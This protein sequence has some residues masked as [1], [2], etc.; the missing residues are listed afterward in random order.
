MTNI[1]TIGLDLAKRKFHFVTL[2]HTNKKIG[3]VKCDREHL[4]AKLLE[5]DPRSTLIAMEA[6]SGSHFWARQISQEGFQVRVI[7]TSDV[8]AYAKTR[9]KNDA[10][11]ALAIAKTA[12][13]LD[14]KWVQPK[15]LDIQELCLVHKLRQ[16]TLKNR[17]QKTNALMGHLH[18]FGYV[19]SSASK[20]SFARSAKIHVL[21][22]FDQDLFCAPTRDL[23]VNEAE[24]IT[25]LLVKERQLDQ[26]IQKR[27][28]TCAVTSRLKTIPGIGDIVGS[29]M[30]TLS[31]ES[32]DNAR[33][34]SASLGLV[35]SQYTTGG[36]IRLGG[37][38]K[39]GCRYTRTMLIQGARCILMGHAKRK[40]KPDLLM[41][42]AGQIHKKKGF[43]VAC[44]AIANKLAR[45]CYG[46]LK[47]NQDYRETMTARQANMSQVA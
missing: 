39:K 7:K 23:L 6:C 40:Q 11:D 46:C 27:N 22:A 24:E 21:A 43:N 44:V 42:W 13:D 1:K 9:Q 3:T 36:M 8:K 15:S 45:I 34:F 47:N 18:E 28:R 5:A 35:P 12:Q 2:D 32:Y 33:D 29:A 19:P 26:Q 4:L 37:I 31:Y 16:S 38:T 25:Q 30:A 17:V 41:Q 10:N 14:M 20:T